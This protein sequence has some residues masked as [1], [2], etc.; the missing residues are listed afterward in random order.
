M[1]TR[2]LAILFV[3][4]L[5]AAPAS[6][7]ACSCARTSPEEALRGSDAAVIAKL[8]KVTPRN[9]DQN[10]R[11][12]FTYRIRRVFKGRQ[13]YEL[14]AGRKLVIESYLSS[15]TCGLP[16]RKRLY[17]LLLYETRRGLSSNLCSLMTPK[18]LRRT[19]EARGERQGAQFG[20]GAPCRK[21]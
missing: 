13:Q 20:R 5:L 17:G 18:R 3:A 9:E 21:T 8:R 10:G 1:K 19:A 15:A 14:H 12:D 6:A 11:A 7:S 2:H 16:Q 4:T